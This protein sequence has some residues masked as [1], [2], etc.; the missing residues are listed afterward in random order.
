MART[1]TAD[2]SRFSGK[3]RRNVD[4][5]VKQSAQ[6]VGREMINPKDGI[7]RGAPFETGVLPVDQGELLA[8]S[9]VA[10]GAGVTARGSTASGPDFVAALAGLDAG[11]TILIALGAPYARRI[12]YGWGSVP[13]RFFVR[14]AIQQWP[15]IVRR[16][17]AQLKD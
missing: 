17:A 10:V 9:F 14:G 1:F 12:E 8:S 2:I 11:E 4:L 15:A 3:A 16:R 5:V 7:V 13:G 6:D